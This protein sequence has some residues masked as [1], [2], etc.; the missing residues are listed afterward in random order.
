M[1]VDAWKDVLV[2]ALLPF[3]RNIEEKEGRKRFLVWHLKEIEIELE[4]CLS[5]PWTFFFIL[6][7]TDAIVSTFLP[8][9]AEG[10][11]S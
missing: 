2:R 7:R 4:A 8:P 3:H 5:K 9:L 6:G 1:Q 11:A 10:N